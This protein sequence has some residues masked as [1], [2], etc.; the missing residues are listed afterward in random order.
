[1]GEDGFSYDWGGD[2]GGDSYSGGS[3]TAD[4]SGIQPG[5]PYSAQPDQSFGSGGYDSMNLP[6]S[7]PASP[8]YTGPGSG[9]NQSGAQGLS[10]LEQ[11]LQPGTGAYDVGNGWTPIQT[12]TTNYW[13]NPA[14]SGAGQY[15]YNQ[16]RPQSS[17][18]FTDYT[19][20]TPMSGGNDPYN[21][22]AR[23]QPAGGRGPAG[24]GGYTQ[25][26]MQRV[27][28]GNPERTLYDRYSQLLQNPEGMASD[29]AY[30]FLFNQGMQAFNRTAGAKGM[31]YSGN[32]ML[33][34]QDYGQG[35][36]YK[37]MNQ[38]LPQYKGGAQEELNRF[39]GPAG[40]LP[41]YAETNNAAT[42]AEG[43]NAAAQQ[44]IPYYQQMLS[45]GGGSGWG[46]PST[47]PGAFN[48]AGAGYGGSS[49]PS[50]LASGYGAP[51]SSPAYGSE[52]DWQGMQD[53]LYGA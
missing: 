52:A 24:G 21:W 47:S 7:D 33:G 45:G 26:P 49:Y 34:A 37:Y 30:K 19:P 35:L 11:T 53:T 2:W 32:T 27:V 38:M 14:S 28:L 36:A 16:G 22:N 51:P 48:T 46:S 12:P 40:L 44:L 3:G 6:A 23:A 8:Y 25:P 1:M 42:S 9:Y 10:G 18:Q 50:R 4:L 15:W 17:G 41:R 13:D 20:I 29:P 43:S 31:R 39:L 5:A